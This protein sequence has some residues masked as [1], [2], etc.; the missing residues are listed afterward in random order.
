MTYSYVRAAFC[1]AIVL[2]AGG[3][4]SAIQNLGG[5]GDRALDYVLPADAF[6]TQ[7]FRHVVAIAVLASAASANAP[8]EEAERAGMIYRLGAAGEQAYKLRLIALTPCVGKVQ[9]RCDQDSARLVEFERTQLRV[10]R[11]ELSLAA[12]ASPDID[13][14]DFVKALGSG[15]PLAI[16]NAF[17]TSWSQF[18]AVS[19][20][21]FDLFANF[22]STILA[23]A[24]LYA[25]LDRTDMTATQKDIAA[26]LEGRLA[27]KNAN[28]AEYLK[29][30]RELERSG[31][32][33]D[34]VTTERLGDNL[35]HAYFGWGNI[36]T[37]SCLTIARG[38]DRFIGTCNEIRQTFVEIAN[39]KADDAR[40][41]RKP[42]AAQTNLAPSPAPSGPAQPAI[43]GRWQAPRVTIQ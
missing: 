18:E 15:N 22:R 26:K 20:L 40:A 11:N 34:L 16:V 14:A 25:M 38:H 28:L 12:D 10:Y 17:V 9:D 36:I 4:S 41:A 7:A 37:D 1:C 21:T 8:E 19:R 30:V 35:K 3:C 31:G 5:T 23:R 43:Q 2:L 27:K 32:F 13:L 29:D 33:L 42:K 6:E 24:E 39:L